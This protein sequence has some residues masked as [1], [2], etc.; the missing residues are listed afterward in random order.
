[1]PAAAQQVIDSFEKTF[2]SMSN[3]WGQFA[4]TVLQSLLDSVKNPAKET[5]AQAKALTSRVTQEVNYA[6]SVSAT[7]VS[8]LNL[9]GMQVA[10]PTRTAQGAPYQYYTDQ[11][12]IAGGGSVSVQ[13]Q[14]GDYLQAIKSFGGDIKTLGK[15]GL[16]KQ[17]LQQLL[18]AGPIQGD[19]MAQSI[20]SGPGGAKEANKLWN[21]INK[22]ANQ[23]GI[24]GAEAV[25]GVPKSKAVSAKADVTGTGAVHALQTAINTLQGK[26]VVVKVV[27][28]IESAGGGG[29]AGGGGKGNV[30]LTNE[31]GHALTSYLTGG[32]AARSVQTATLKQ[33]KRTGTSG[34]RLPG[35]AN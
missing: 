19:A 23:L 33:A 35:Y 10:T 16:N 27:L 9:P 15:Q 31:V 14:M 28:D 34:L 18:G 8:D 5:A 22:A 7:A 21:Q 29:G 11:A 24:T 12:T 32:H 2:K 1:M 13:G 6:K 20:L 17:M 26:T 4:T 30:P 3:P 25:Y